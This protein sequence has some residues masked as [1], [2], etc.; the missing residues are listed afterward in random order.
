MWM[1]GGNAGIGITLV[2]E[3]RTIQW[4]SKFI[5]A[6]FPTKAEARTILEGH[7]MLDIWANEEG[8]VYSDS[9]ET[10]QALGK[11]KPEITDWRTYE[12]LW[13]AW[14]LQARSQGKL[15]VA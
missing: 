5:Q 3:G 7:K 6:L 8:T 4:V 1:E 13:E 2:R 10:I 12:K 11:N 9:K 14:L 15:T